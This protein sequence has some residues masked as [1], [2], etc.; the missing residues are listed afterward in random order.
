MFLGGDPNY[1]KLIITG[2]PDVTALEHS[3]ELHNMQLVKW[4]GQMSSVQLWVSM[5]L[6]FICWQDNNLG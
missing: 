6:Q 4:V 5:L 2:I 3:T 1:T